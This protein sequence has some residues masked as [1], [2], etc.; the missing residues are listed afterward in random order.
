MP[1]YSPSRR[2][3]LPRR[4]WLA[5]AGGAAAAS[6]VSNSGAKESASGEDCALGYGTYGLP[7]YSLNDAIDLVARVGY[8]SI[9][10]VTITGYHG[11]PDQVSA[12]A[13]KEARQRISDSGLELGALM[14]L[15]NPTEDEAA[16][17]ANLDLFREVLDL[18]RDLAP[19]HPPLIQTVLGGGEWEEKKALYRDTLG[20]RLEAA[21]GSGVILA[22]KPHRGHA[23]SRPEEATWLIEQLD[24][25]GRLRI[26]YDYSHY[27]FRDMPPEETVAAALPHTGYL[28]VKDAVTEDDGKV[29]FRLPGE[30]G[31]M[32]HAE[33]LAQFHEGGYRG[34]V[35]CEVSS[36]V[37]RAEGFDPEAAAKTCYANMVRIFDEAGVSR[38]KK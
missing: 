36:Q 18:A 17:K 28:V 9:E 5:L 38:P 8:D 32:P 27:A 29:R 2:D 24:A 1:P 20:A 21:A 11:A 22:I 7:G 16:A 14:G 4:R 30:S 37:W 3:P 34:E 31:E 12:P 6:A 13:R 10:I 15:P 23:M 35:C 25:A 26:V 19:V 33:I